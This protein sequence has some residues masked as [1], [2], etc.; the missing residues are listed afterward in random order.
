M[1]IFR[2]LRVFGAALS[3]I[4]LTF[5]VPASATPTRCAPLNIRAMTYN[6]RL[7]TPVDGENGWSHR[8]SWLSDQII[9]LAPDIFGLQEVVI[10]QKRD[11]AHDLP[12][13]QIIGNGR[14]DGV[15]AGESSPIGFRPERFE[16]LDNGTFWLSPTPDQPGKGW[17]AA[18][19]RVATWARLR[20]RAS[21]RAVLALNTHWDH[22]G[23]EARRQSGLQL[24]AWLSANARAGEHLILLGDFNT[25]IDN[26]AMAALVDPQPH[27][28]RLRDSRAASQ[29]TPF[30][31]VGTFNA[32]HLVPD[33]TL[34]IDHILVGDSVTVSRYAVVAQH[35]DG[36]V[37][38][39]H[40]PVFADLVLGPPC[41]PAIQPGRQVAV[42][43]TTTTYPYLLFTPASYRSGGRQRAPL[44][45]F[46]H[47]SGERGS[48][49]RR[50]AIHGPPSIAASEVGF[51][52]VTV[53]P[54]L[55]ADG[56]WDVARL[57]ATLAH[58][59]TLV[60]VDPRRMVLTGLSLGGHASWRWATAHPGLF[61]AVVPIAGRGDS[62]TAC[63][64]RSTPVW[65]F[66][67]QDD[68]VVPAT[69]SSAMIDAIRACG[70]AAEVRMT[71]YPGVGHDSWTR[72]Y[73]DPALYA[74]IEEQFRR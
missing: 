60:R 48:D 52:Y 49:L 67:G 17:D 46:L 63:A 25:A 69:G 74:W 35:V 14:D 73:A 8:R 55:E 30:G 7:D 6:I 41:P 31:P 15:D 3:L 32:F 61:A 58:A 68:S 28:A 5:A 64:L 16:L 34:T 45:I 4:A 50:V 59:R 71:L 39:D 27:A 40:F 21:Q 19:P 72:T 20:D 12:A 22:I 18:F 2:I 11:I 57:E 37:M 42:S 43:A 47:G 54:Q 62:A 66:H 36:R 13:Y 44:M 65:A 33:E 38:S 23:I 24:R 1:D 10:N 51:P 53:S 56:D 70:G 9:W 29:T 26:E